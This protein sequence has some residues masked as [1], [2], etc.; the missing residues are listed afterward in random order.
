M[1]PEDIHKIANKMNISWNGDKTF[2]SWCNKLVGKKHLDDMSEQ[3]LIDV[4]NKIKNGQYKENL[5]EKWS[6][7]YKKSINCSNPKGF[8]QKAHCAGRKKRNEMYK[9]IEEM[10]EVMGMMEDVFGHRVTSY[11]PKD[12]SKLKNK[13]SQPTTD[14]EREDYVDIVEPLMKKKSVKPAVDDDMLNSFLDID[15]RVYKRDFKSTI[16][17]DDYKKKPEKIV[18]KQKEP[19]EK[20]DDTK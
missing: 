13:L 10:K 4:Y 16:D 9:E 17:L 6:S 5:S 1:K 14:S 3:E 12:T 8:S 19:S 18:F 2:M 7:K 20:K 15:T 11:S